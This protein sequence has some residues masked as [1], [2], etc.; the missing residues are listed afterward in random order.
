[1]LASMETLIRELDLLPR[2]SAVLCAVSGGADSVCL[3]H[4]LYHLRPK[5]G[6][7]LAAAHYDHGLRGEHS[8][9]DAA[10]V[11][12]FVRLCCP[13]QHLPDGTLLPAVPL[14]SGSGNVAAEAQRRGTGIEE[15]AREMRY[16]F[17]DQAAREAGCDFIA[18]A[19]NADDNAETVLFH[20]ARGS[21]LRGLTGIPPIRG[22]L[23]RPLLT[24][25]RREIEA[26]LS[27][28]GLPHVEDQSNRDDT[29]A[30][31]R[32]RHQVVPVL[33]E[34]YPGFVSRLA[35]TAALLRADEA[36]LSDQARA[37]TDQAEPI[38]DGLS[39]PAA[40]IG[41][42]P[43]PLAARAVRQLIGQINGGD[44]DCGMAHL[45]QVIQ[46]CRG[47][48]PSARTDLPNGLTVR[49]EYTK[50]IL[51]RKSAPPALRETQ[52]P[53]PGRC[54]AGGWQI[55][56]AA[57]VYSGPRQTPYD[58][59]LDRDR[60]PALTL[61]PR[62]TGDRLKLPGRPSKTIK[63]WCIDEQIPLRVRDHLPVFTC[64]GQV[65]AAAGLGPDQSFLPQPGAEAWHITVSALP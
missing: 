37:I 48:D 11:S 49:R 16:S 24:T 44:S 36:L 12:Q 62:Q 32:I 14:F 21:G 65:A 8:K 52:V 29:Y 61:R 13:E 1:M 38:P 6:F 57:Q 28:Y 26:Y 17:L 27:Y 3:L 59:W 54:S 22:N 43:A 56:C 33:E 58:F 46:L 63:K 45:E 7:S 41:G 20:L 5:L 10:F 40:L 23:I 35:D 47:S 34:L 39:I 51:S 53:L 50:L 25:S 15:T 18:T 31:N 60:V 19:H 9:Q 30:R 42:A 4:A 2:G 64:A 55:C